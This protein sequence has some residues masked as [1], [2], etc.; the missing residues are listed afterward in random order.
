[1]LNES[2]YHTTVECVV[3]QCVEE[4]KECWQSVMYRINRN[5]NER[6]RNTKRRHNKKLASL[7]LTQA[8]KNAKRSPQMIDNFVVN[9]S[10]VQPTQAELDLLNK[11]LNF[12][13]PPLGGF[14]VEEAAKAV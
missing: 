1:M 11:G 10:S 5:L 13:I 4:N 12:A 3:Y 9:L 14:G 2:A 8:P 6:I 7:A